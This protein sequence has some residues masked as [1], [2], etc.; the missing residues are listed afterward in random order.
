MVSGQDGFN[1]AVQAA[2]LTVTTLTT[3]VATTIVPGAV[4]APLAS[5]QFNASSSGE[6]VQVSS[7]VVTDTKGTNAVYTDVYNL[8]MKD[9]S[10]QVLT[11]TSSTT[12]NANT[13]TFD[14]TNPIMVNA[15]TPV[16]AYLYGSVISGATAGSGANYAHTFKV[17]SVTAT[18]ATT[19]NS[20][21]SPSYVG[22]GQVS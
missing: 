7:L 2:S 11:T 10:G 1:R 3:P 13:V 22:S 15:T 20:I 19:G 21:G 8:V 14:F 5:V 17:S 16:T 6:P 18:G 9:A 12:T 4:D